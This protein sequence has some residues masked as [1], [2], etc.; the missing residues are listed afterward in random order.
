MIRIFVDSASD[1]TMDDLKAHGLELFPISITIGDDSY[2]DGVNLQRDQLYEKLAAGCT[3]PTTSQ[4]SIQFFLDAFESAKEQGD[5][6]IYLALSSALSGTYQSA[7]TAKEMVG[8]DGV[9]IIDTLSATYTIKIMADHAAALRRQGH[10]AAEIVTAIE[11][12]KSRVKVIAV[13]DSLEYLCR[14]GRVNRATAAIGTL[15]NIKPIITVTPDGRIGVPAKCIGIGKSIAYLIKHLQDYPIDTNFPLYPIYSYGTKNC[16]KAEEKL[17]QAGIAME[18]RMQ[19]GP[20]I[21]T[22]I[23]PEALGIVYVQK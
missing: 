3:F 2:Q 12:L 17:A 7:C 18:P 23:G 22:H 13:P 1:Y 8:Y 20:T 11:A 6:L 21:G 9:Y 16:E 4:P 5:E 19:I 15:A 10:S 14:G